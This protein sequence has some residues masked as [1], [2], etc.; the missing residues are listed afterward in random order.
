VN[1]RS[2]TGTQDVGAG[3]T[4]RIRGSER[5]AKSRLQDDS[6]FSKVLDFSMNHSLLASVDAAGL[7]GVQAAQDDGSFYFASE[8]GTILCVDKKSLSLA[9]RC[10]VPANVT[11]PPAVSEGLI[12]VNSSEGT[13]SCLSGGKILWQKKL[14]PAVYSSPVISGGLLVLAD[15]RGRVTAINRDG[16]GTAWTSELKEGVFSTPTANDG[17]VYVVTVN[18]G[19][20]KLDLKT[21]KNLWSAKLDGRV[22]DCPAVVVDGSLFTATSAGRMYKLSADDGRVLLSLK[23]AGPVTGPLML[24]AGL[25][26]ARGA[27]LGLFSRDGRPMSEIDVL[28]ADYLASAEG[29]VSDSDRVRFFGIDGTLREAFTKDRPFRLLAA[30]PRLI[31]YDGITIKIWE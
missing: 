12:Y 10:S 22:V 4:L 28:G 2:G 13:L 24:K 1:V 31:T 18:A 27:G 21:G 16:S 9:W 6:S 17:A 30:A 20:F 8:N 25:V 14:G 5:A 19:V 26:G 11:A 15:T 29:I 23:I 3:E 7:A